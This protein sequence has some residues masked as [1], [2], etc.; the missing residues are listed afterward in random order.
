MCGWAEVSFWNLEWWEV[1]SSI[2]KFVVE[3]RWRREAG[4]WRCVGG[5][6]DMVYW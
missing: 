6:F 2:V 5:Y 4:T 1:S 3:E